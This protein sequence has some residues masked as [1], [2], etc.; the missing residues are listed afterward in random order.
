MVKHDTAGRASAF[1]R[2]TAA[3]E[4]AKAEDG[5]PAADAVKH[6]SESHQQNTK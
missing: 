6:Y 5:N 1:A 3:A 2:D 4:V